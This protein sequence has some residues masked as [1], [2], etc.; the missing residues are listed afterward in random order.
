MTF[1]LILLQAF[2]GVALGTIFVLVALGLSLIFGLLTIVNFAHSQFFML[3]AYV[4]VVVLAVTGSFW[5]ALVL[6]PLV[7]G[8][9]GMVC[10]RVL[11]RPLYGRGIDYPLL[12]TFGLGLIILELVR[13]FAGTEGI[14]FN[15]PE[16]L[17]GAVDLGVFFFPKYRLFL[18]GVTAAILVALW[19][20]LEKTPY[21][22]IIRAGARDPEIVQ[23]LGVDVSRVWLIVFGIGTGLAALAGVLAAPIRGVFPEMGVPVLVE[24]FVVT[25]V[26]G[27]GSLL[28]AVIAGLAVG[29]TVS[30]T[31]LFY[32]EMTTLS[33]FLL[34]AVVLVFRPRGLFGR[35]GV[36]D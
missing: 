10:E 33:M 20:F 29:I 28:G 22:L 4:G 30:M 7:V 14:P 1:D 35:A 19:F 12:L 24:A 18:I 2:T 32:P 8:A 27:M 16:A 26:G 34:M 5:A 21:G 9:L 17:T 36:L 15:T 31:S 11:I 6:V 3:G 13:I 23:V 25:V